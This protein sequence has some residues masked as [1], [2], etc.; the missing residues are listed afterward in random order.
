MLFT[1]HNETKKQGTFTFGATINAVTHHSL[2]ATV[3]QEF[4]NG[5][6]CQ[7][8]NISFT[9]TNEMIFALG[10]APKI[11]TPE[12]GFVLQVHENGVF[13]SARDKNNLIYGFFTLL[14]RIRPISTNEN[15]TVF[16]IPCCE[17]QDYAEIPTRMVHLCIFP[18]T[19]LFFIKKFIRM[20][21]FLRYTHIIVE[22]WGMLKYDCLKELG[23]P[24]AYTKEEIRP[25]FQETNT[26]GL[27]V[28]PMFNHWG[29]ATASRVNQGKHVI[30]DQ[31]L[32]LSPLFDISGWNWD[33][34][35][36]ATKKLHRQIREELIELCGEGEYFHIGCDEAY[37]YDNSYE[38][39]V[40]YINEIEKELQRFGRKTVMWGDM[41]LLQKD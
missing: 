37:G 7:A 25:L 22:F 11:S 36:P 33:I 20:S 21:A 17:I 27:K 30:L 6:C 5:F 28:I 10:N 39:V 2:H 14:E 41:F 16:E 34:E 8:G 15:D 40:N 19:K 32:K 4:W 23:L 1:P 31:N 35:N 3:F 24:N 26:L 12:K 18:E 13:I 38:P 29:H 9:E